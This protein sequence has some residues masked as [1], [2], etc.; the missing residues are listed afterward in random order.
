MSDSQVTYDQQ[1]YKFS[2]FAGRWLAT[3]GVM[4]LAESKQCYWLLDVIASYV[5]KLPSIRALDYMLV[6]DCKLNKTGSGCKFTISHEVNGEQIVV[7]KQAIGFTTLES[8]IKLW[9]INETNGFYDAKCQ[10]VLLLPEEY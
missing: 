6:I 1:Y 2:P 5:H 10:T 8:D 3:S 7:I 4:A 9:A